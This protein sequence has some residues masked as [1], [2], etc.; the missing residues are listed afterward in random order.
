M[1]FFSFIIFF[2]YLSCPVFPQQVW[3]FG[4]GA[5]VDFSSGHARPIYNGKLF[6]LEGCAVACDAK[7]RLVFYTDGITVWNRLHREMLN[8][9]ELK[10]SQS[11]TQ[12]AL[13]IQ[14]PGL[15]GRYFLFTLDEKAGKN[16]L[17]YSVVEATS[18]EGV[19]T[20]KNISLL[21]SS[22][23]KLAGVMHANN[24][25]VWVIAHQWNS[26]KFYVYPVTA[27]GIGTPIVSAIGLAHAETGAGEN[28]EAIGYLG[29]SANGKKIASAVCYRSTRNVELFDFDNV[30]GKVSNPSYL[31]LAGLPYGLSFSP[32]NT[33]L[34]VSFLKGKS[35]IIQYD[36]KDKAVSEILANNNENMLGALQLGPD[37]KIYM[38]RTD[39]CL[40]VIEY[41][42]KKASACLYKHCAIDLSPASGNFGLPN[43]SFS[44]SPAAQA[45]VALTSED[46]FD[47]SKIIEKPFSG[48]EQ[49]VMTDMSVCGDDYILSAKNPGAS[50]KWS[51]ADTAQKIKISTS[52]VYGIVISRQ[53]CTQSDS[54]RVRFRKELAVFTYLPSFNPETEFLNSEFYYTIDAVEGFQL[55]VFGLKNKKVLFETNNRTIMWKGKNKKGN[56]VRE[57]KYRWQVKYTPDCPKGS[58]AVIQEGTVFVKRNK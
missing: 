36:M 51:T 14:Q 15:K 29:V 3:Y 41:P 6:T 40:D 27:A 4:N 11:A 49:L 52:G 33:K 9:Q 32:D 53:G 24:K 30:T 38:T 31:S 58:E 35:G 1:R 21:T 7:G 19:I 17:C 12:A 34:Y 45:L 48:R 42:N 47:C 13:I 18:G 2:S 16:G 50:Y 56:F 57:G 23:E 37:G 25:D 44:E 43:A 26:N 54:I 20:H 22:T 39:N 10:G 8:G 46:S 55:Q 5:G 28:R